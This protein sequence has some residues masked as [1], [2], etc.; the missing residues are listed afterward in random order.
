MKNFIYVILSIL[1]LVSCNTQTQQQEKKEEIK[2]QLPDEMKIDIQTENLNDNIIK[3]SVITNFPD[4]TNFTIDAGRPYKR[5]N[6]NADYNGELYYQYSVYSINGK[7][8]FQ[9]QVDDKKW[10]DE[11]EKF[12]KMDSKIKNIKNIQDS[13]EINVLYTPK[14]NQTAANQSILGKNGENIKGK[15]VEKTSD[16]YTFSSTKKLKYKI[17]K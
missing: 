16:F 3:V 4:S 10:L 6:D 7:I 15:G 8:D 14:G 13:I 11:F 1:V 2:F 12:K 9:I 17:I 5:V